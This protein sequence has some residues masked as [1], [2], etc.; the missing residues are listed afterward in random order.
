[1][2][3]DPV[4]STPAEDPAT[5]PKEDPAGHPQPEPDK[6]DHDDPRS[7]PSIADDSLPEEVRASNP[8]SAG[9][10]GLSGGMGVSSERTGPAGRDHRG[11][12]ISGTGSVG[13]AVTGTDGGLDTSAGKWDAVD[14]SQ[15]ELYPDRDEDRSTTGSAAEFTGHVDR[16]VGEP[17]PEPI[18]D[19]KSRR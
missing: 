11:S 14:V 7:D 17:R 16:T 4:P 2:S 12:D 15:D 10:Q 3:T 9:P 8:N 13:G 5:Q 1:M 19:E 18:A 6:P